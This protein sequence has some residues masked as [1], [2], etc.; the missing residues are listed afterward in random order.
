VPKGY[1]E[2]PAAEEAERRREELARGPA[3][4]EE[5]EEGLAVYGATKDEPE[6]HLIGWLPEVDPDEL[7]A[8]GK[9]WGLTVVRRRRADA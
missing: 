7:F 6:R 9:A 2:G 5:A 3:A 8:S 1:A 4:E